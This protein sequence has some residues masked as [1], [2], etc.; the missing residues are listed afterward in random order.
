MVEVINLI[1]SGILQGYDSLIL[2]LPLWAQQ[3]LNLFLLVVLILIYSVFI[4]KFYRFIGTK[5]I[6]ELN[7]NRYNRSKHPFYVKLIAGV[8][9]FA[10][11]ILILPFLIFVWFSIFTFF[12]ILLTESM[13]VAQILLIS[14]TIIGAIRMLSYIPNYGEALAKEVAKL[15]PFTL[16]AISI[17]NPDFFDIERIITHINELSGLFNNIII[18]LLFII[19]LEIVLRFFEFIFSLFG[20]VNPK[21]MEKTEEEAENE[22]KEK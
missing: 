22:A 14:V 11:Y 5:N 13:N 16:L 20:L 12:L 8:F 19:I 21:Y 18:Y 1:E 15:L 9:Y 7:L 2:S 10:E 3:F 4:W 6:L 17:L